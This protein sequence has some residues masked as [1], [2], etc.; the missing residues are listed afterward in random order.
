M[1]FFDWFPKSQVPVG[2]IKKTSTDLNTAY[3]LLRD[4]IDPAL[5]LWKYSVSDGQ[6]PE[7]VSY[8]LY[9]RPDY[10]WTILILNNIINPYTDWLIPQRSLDGYIQKKYQ[11]GLIRGYDKNNSPVVL[12]LSY[13]PNGVHHFLNTHTG[14][15]DE[16]EDIRLRDLILTEQTAI[17]AKSIADGDSPLISASAALDKAFANK[18]ANNIMPITNYQYESNQNE[19]RRLIEVISPSYIFRCVDDFRRMLNAN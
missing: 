17:M 2:Q 14:M 16:Y 12:K 9:K 3:F 7:H 5:M 8:E 4:K 1:I 15:L 10:Y 6:R 19:E 11:S 18:I 13:G